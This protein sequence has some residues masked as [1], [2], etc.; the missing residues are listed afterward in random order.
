M[1]CSEKPFFVIVKKT[2]Q[3]F[4][5]DND[6]IY[7]SPLATHRLS[8]ATGAMHPSLLVKSDWGLN[9]RK[10]ISN[11][12]TGEAGGA[13][14]KSADGEKNI[15]R[16]GT[17]GK[18]G[19][20]YPKGNAGY[21]MAKIGR[22]SKVDEA[23]SVAELARILSD[24]SLRTNVNVRGSPI[25]FKRLLDYIQF[26]MVNKV[27]NDSS[28]YLARPN[29]YHVME[30]VHTDGISLEEAYSTAFRDSNSNSKV[31]GRAYFVT[32][33]RVAAL[34]SI[35]RGIPTVYQAGKTQSYYNLPITNVVPTIRKI[36]KSM[37]NAKGYKIPETRTPMNAHSNRIQELITP[38]GRP[39]ITS[40]PLFAWF[41]DTRNKVVNTVKRRT[42]GTDFHKLTVTEKVLV[43]FYW[44][45]NYPGKNTEVIEYFLA[46]LDSFHDFTSPRA[47][48]AFKNIW[49]TNKK[50]NSPFNQSKTKTRDGINTN[51]IPLPQQQHK[52]LVK[53]LGVDIYRKVGAYN[54]SIVNTLSKTNKRSA[55]P[56]QLRVAHFLFFITN[57]L[58]SQ[59]SLIEKFEEVSRDIM[60][61]MTSNRPINVKG[62][63][64]QNQGKN[65]CSLLER[66]DACVVIDA[67]NGSVP[68]CL[69][70]YSVFHNVG[71][72]DPVD[73]GILSWGEV[74]GEGGCVES[75]RVEAAKKRRQEKQ[76]AALKASKNKD[77][78]LAKARATRKK[79]INNA[80]QNA[81]ARRR[82]LNLK[83]GAEKNA[84]AQRLA[85]RSTPNNNPGN[86][87]IRNNN[88]GNTRIRNNNPGTA[89]NVNSTPNNNRGKNPGNNRRTPVISVK[90]ENF[91]KFLLNNAP[92]TIEATKGLL[93]KINRN[94]N[95]FNNTQKGVVRNVL[96]K[97]LRRRNLPE[98]MEML[99]RTTKA[100]IFPNIGR[101]T[102]SMATN[103]NVPNNLIQSIKK[104][105][106][107]LPP[108]LRISN[109][110]INEATKNVT[111]TERLLNN[112]KMRVN[113]WTKRIIKEK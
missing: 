109:A 113:T 89:M 101:Q 9:K 99:A 20:I 71:L 102:R 76:R 44:V 60:I 67:L 74:I 35:V 38:D 5:F 65:L 98:N 69:K 73:K 2:G 80:R 61:Q 53:L 1:S 57:L 3:G 4:N 97:I 81:L 93:N 79:T 63:F 22:G 15:V 48:G 75:K 86:T 110:D 72:L 17:E 16:Q 51:N 54:K 82:G 25:E 31:Y 96:N 10:T 24:L 112:L 27:T 40:G 26:M 55:I 85:A 83:R 12:I 104:M 68:D 36:I 50:I 7:S 64:D 91:N 47:T 56:V 46:I 58:G 92:Y 41:L 42:V 87:R 30:A 6:V 77:A 111:K 34:A 45:F 105:N 33:D 28:L 108:N 19:I 21:V 95:T 23:P 59:S 70:K 49:P 39:V 106:E 14:L 13:T 43:I 84:R 94:Q 32:F 11:L 37:L 90:M 62:I 18:T 78:R 107:K 88:P 52:F 103:P 29:N 8:Q 100:K 66:E